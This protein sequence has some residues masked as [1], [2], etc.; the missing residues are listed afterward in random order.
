MSDQI[1]DEKSSANVAD[2]GV[3]KEK[4]S[5][6]SAARGS[7]D[8]LPLPESVDASLLATDGDLIEARAIAARMTNDEVKSILL[9]VVK[10][11]N[12]DPNFPFPVLE[13]I[14]GFIANPAVFENPEKHEELFAEMKL[15]AALI[16][17]NSPY[18]EVRAVVDNHDDPS[19]PV[20]TVRAWVIGMIFSVLLAFINQLFSIRQPSIL[21][22]SNVAQILSYP[23]GKLWEKVMPDYGVNM[24]GSR[25]SLNPGPFNK[26]EHMLVTIMANVAYSTPYTN[27]IIW[28]QYLPTFFNQHYA[29]QFSYQI[30]IGLSTNFIG[31]G[32]AGLTRRFLVYPSFCVWPSSLVTI[33]LNTAFHDDN[34]T[35]VKAP[36]RKMISM[37]RYRFFLYAFS[38]MFIYFW[39]PDFIFQAL[40]IFSWLSWIAPDNVNLNAVVGFNNGLGINPW[41]TFDWN[42]LLYNSLDPLMI[43]F[44]STLNMTI[45]MAV[46]T[47]T[48][49]GLWYTNAWNTGHLPIN[50]NGVFDNTGSRF[51]VTRVIDSR[52]IFDSAKYTSYSMAYLAAGNICVYIFFF[53]IYPATVVYIGLYHRYE[54]T[55]GFKSLWQSFK[56]KKKDENGNAII[57]PLGSDVHNRLMSAYKEAPEWWYMSLLVISIALGIGGIAGYETFTTPGVIFYGLALCLIFVVPCGIV[58]AMTGAQ[59]TLNVLAEFIGGSWVEGNALAMNFFKCYGYVT[60]AHALAFA[61]D[62]KLAH[63]VKIPPRT[64]FI[65]QVV[66]TLVSTFVCTGVLNFQMN[67]I[68]GVCTPDAPNRFTCPGINT[69]FTASVLWGTIGPKK[70]FGS[71][72]QYTAALV[73]FPIGA[74][75]PFIFWAL[76]RKYRG[77]RWLRQVH[78][79]AMLYGSLSLSP[80]NLSYQ[81]PAVPIAWLSWIYI[82]QRYL[83]LWSKYNFVLSG[84]FSSGVAVAAI[85]IF[86]ALQW[87]GDISLD[88]WG[89]Q[90][91][92]Q[93][94]EASAC[95]RLPLAKG[96]TFGPPA[97]SWS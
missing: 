3:L 52:G 13:K 55:M 28:A 76:Q 38:A 4:Q 25:I 30:L 7:L 68:P 43:P 91:V 79:V 31:Y 17:N 32:I 61:N 70:V 1:K 11:H 64:T 21:V 6:F 46:S 95:V 57:E 80:Y 41:P 19:L 56:P 63:Y 87:G 81:W 22:A 23:L 96:E 16:T 97:G 26:K 58:A 34:S 69:F 82:K 86:F 73:G 35:P 89:N 84:A 74:A 77:S 92:S 67:M 83:A 14:R 40:S 62:L 49:L 37:S 8:E 42:T 33:A 36:F 90:V 27:N 20:S 71:G 29:G 72:G 9:D 15:E 78:P 12:D 5:A 50:S 59:V 45:G 2:G 88:W 47:I 93:G 94:C 44:F 18:S 66:A 65:A 48:A 75:L 39:F 51:N 10:I 24:F 60:C 54:I 85:I 53:A